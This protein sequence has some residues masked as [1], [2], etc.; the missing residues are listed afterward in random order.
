MHIKNGTLGK[1]SHHGIHGNNMSNILIEN[2]LIEDFE[3]AGIALNGGET[4]LYKRLYNS[5]P[6]RSKGVINIISIYFL[7]SQNYKV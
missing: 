2:L 3:V 1:S 5:K 6:V 4:D 7:T